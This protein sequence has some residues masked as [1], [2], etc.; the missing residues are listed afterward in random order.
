[1]STIRCFMDQ[2]GRHDVIN[3]PTLIHYFLYMFQPETVVLSS[4]K[5]INFLYL[6]DVM[7]VNSVL[8][9]HDR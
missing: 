7:I 1:M 3:N 4:C 9:V 6:T 2:Y 8:I 5:F